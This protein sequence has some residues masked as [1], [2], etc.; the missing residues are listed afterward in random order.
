M[1]VRD[2]L[3]VIACLLVEKI[4]ISD[5]QVNGYAREQTWQAATDASSPAP[6]E[7]AM[8][9]GKVDTM[10]PQMWNAF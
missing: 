2:D 9:Q 5:E 3:S 1:T 10:P 8:N 6:R 4:A 7:E